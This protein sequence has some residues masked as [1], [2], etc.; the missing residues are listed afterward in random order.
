MQCNSDRLYT[1]AH[2]RIQMK[3]FSRTMLVMQKKDIS[4]CNSKEIIWCIRI[5]L[6]FKI[7]VFFL[8]DV[9]GCCVVV[10]SDYKLI[11][12]TVPITNNLWWPRPVALPSVLPMIP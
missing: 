6:T 8:Y 7:K 11:K 4:V 2:V 9:E 12:L 1:S 3:I 10:G 5:R